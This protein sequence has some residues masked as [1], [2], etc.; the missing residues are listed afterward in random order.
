MALG[1]TMLIS[2]LVTGQEH[3]RNGNFESSVGWLLHPNNASIADCE[4]EDAGLRLAPPAN[5][6]AFGR[7]RIEGPLASGTYRVSGRIK[8]ISGT[9]SALLDVRQTW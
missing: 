3:V 8:R 6:L 1:A 2:S 5:Q 9:A 4:A 7:Q